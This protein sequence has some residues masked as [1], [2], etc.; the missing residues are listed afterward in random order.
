[1]YI[2]AFLNI[3]LALA[4]LCASKAMALGL[5]EIEVESLLASP[6]LA[7]VRLDNRNSDVFL[8]S[9]QVRI[10]LESGLSG[11][12]ASRV[13]PRLRYRFEKLNSRTPELVLYTQRPVMNPLFN[14]KVTVEWDE[15]T[16]SRAYDVIVDPPGYDLG[17]PGS[18]RESSAVDEPNSVEQSSGISEAPL[19]VKMESADAGGESRGQ[20]LASD[21]GAITTFGPTENGSSLWRIARRVRTDKS[22]L[23]L[24]QWMHGLWAK[25][26]NAFMRTNM[27]LLKTGVILEVPTDRQVAEVSRQ[28][29]YQI[30][31]AH[32]AELAHGNR[33]PADEA[34][35]VTSSSA[36]IEPLSTAN[37]AEVSAGTGS[38]STVSAEPEREPALAEAVLVSTTDELEAEAPGLPFDVTDESLVTDAL[39]VE[40]ESTPSPA[41]EM[42]RD[43]GASDPG[44]PAL[45]APMSADS[46]ELIDS[47]DSFKEAD[48]ADT[49]GVEAGAANDVT[50][51]ITG[52]VDDAGKAFS[53]SIN[54]V[55]GIVRHNSGWSN[56]ALGSLLTFLVLA[57]WRISQPAPRQ[58]AP[59]RVASARTGES[60]LPA[61]SRNEPLSEHGVSENSPVFS[62]ALANVDKF[63]DA[64][65]MQ[66][67][68]WEIKVLLGHGRNLFA[69]EKLERAI[70]TYPE[71]HQFKLLLADLYVQTSDIEGLEPLV[72][73]LQQRTGELD[74]EQLA[75]FHAIED[76]LNKHR[77]QAAPAT[78]DNSL[79]SEESIVPDRLVQPSDGDCQPLP[80]NTGEAAQ[81]QVAPWNNDTEGTLELVFVKESDS[82]DSSEGDWQSI[83]VKSEDAVQG[84]APGIDDI[85]QELIGNGV[86]S[87]TEDEGLAAADEDAVAIDQ[88]LAE[89]NLDDIISDDTAGESNEEEFLVLP[90]S[91]DLLESIAPE[92]KGQPEAVSTEDE[93]IVL[94]ADEGIESAIDDEPGIEGFPEE[95]LDAEAPA[96]EDRPK[97]LSFPDA[98]KVSYERDLKAFESEVTLTLQA[99]RDQMQQLNERLFRQ[100]RENHELKKQ[101]QAGTPH[102][103]GKKQA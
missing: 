3:S 7:R 72:Q 93:E 71:N 60:G 53:T 38:D 35:S 10:N 55:N 66:V 75:H 30:Y 68:L 69:R 101:L 64:S 96:R 61:P 33:M 74:A 11:D 32:L 77:H 8:D 91:L 102:G 92:D 51:V 83:D 85:L 80:E 79:D 99:M 20:E 41:E 22:D 44:E 36:Q 15:G 95:S 52:L 67:R 81:Q 49:G 28:Q 56:I 13:T 40:G 12:K 100:E 37:I 27:H 39:L 90:D 14:I 17:E 84:D 73:T 54:A 88:Y 98:A 94:A 6:F 58:E 70:D 76:E 26:A 57:L 59:R 24:Y 42:I 78:A 43:S 86:S 50:S 63:Q 47:G 21:A 87:T 19:P 89:E 29:A 46:S 25:N 18:G 97:V 5:G 34:R 16:L 103:D 1:M 23:S 4:L 62:Q 2:R 31:G 48:A 65:E 9:R 82:Q 45:F